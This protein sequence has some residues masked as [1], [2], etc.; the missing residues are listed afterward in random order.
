MADFCT[1]VDIENVLQI[2]ITDPA[3]LASAEMAI[4]L[5]TEAI[6]NRTGQQI[7]LVEDEEIT[8]DVAPGTRTRVFL[9]QIPV[10]E[11]SAVVED[12]VTL[13][14]G[15]DYALG[16]NG[17]LYRLNGYWQ[18]GVQVLA[19]T[20]SHGYATLPDD[21]VGV[22]ARAA[23]RLFQAGLKAAASEGVPGIQA[24]SLGDYSVTYQ[25]EGAAEG[26]LGASGARV[27][28][29]SEMDILDKYRA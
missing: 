10:I 8:L 22:A 7:E 14:A 5:V 26:L 28:L 3:Q 13:V 18:A 11:V 16:Q 9:P 2:E 23:S 25:Q 27:L 24:T 17:I 29:M 1:V 6:R 21:V 15:T 12:G 4:D 20:Y 19:V